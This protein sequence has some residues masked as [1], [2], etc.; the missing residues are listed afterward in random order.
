MK[1][2]FVKGVATFYGFSESSLVGI[3]SSCGL[4]ASARS[5]H[6]WNMSVVGVWC[7][8]EALMEWARL[9]AQRNASVLE[10]RGERWRGRG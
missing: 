6:L 3:D 2:F 10:G 5:S 9:R 8:W 1:I 7:Q 4:L